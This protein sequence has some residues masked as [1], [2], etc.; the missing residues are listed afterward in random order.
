MNKKLKQYIDSLNTITNTD[1][2]EI[3]LKHKALPKKEKN[4]IEL[5]DYLGINKSGEAYRLWVVN[6]QRKDGTL[7]TAFGT[8]KLVGGTT[9]ES[10]EYQQLYKEKVKT[11]SA[12]TELR[13]NL[14][15]EARLEQFKEDLFESIS[16]LDTLPK[17]KF[18][19]NTGTTNAEAV[20][21]LSDLHLGAECNNFYNKYNSTIARNRLAKVT[22]DTINYCKL[23]NVKQLNIINLGDCIHGLIH[24]DSRITQQ[25]DLITQITTAADYIAQVLTELQK[26]APIITYRSCSDNHSRTNANKEEAIESENFG[27][28]IDWYLEERLKNTNIKFIKDNLDYGL[29]RFKLNNGKLVFFMHG[30]QD[31][32]NSVMQNCVGATKEY[33]DY[34]FIGHIHNLKQKS[35]QN[36]QVYAN[37]SIVGTE[38]YALGKRLFSDPAQKLLIFDKTNVLDINIMLGGIQS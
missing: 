25:F 30:H 3:G 20:L 35:F 26:A 2:Y 1:L 28:I 8:S 12:I 32:I 19:G 33:P 34:I 9:E 16:L 29:G 10:E 38:Q 6:E 27:K 36:C 21:L 37:G 13:K 23:N 5:A 4:W 15:N 14:S 7:S 18:K 31:S 17:I 11:R 22:T 24:I